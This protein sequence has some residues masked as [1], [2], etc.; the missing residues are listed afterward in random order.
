MKAFYPTKSCTSALSLVVATAMLSSIAVGQEA[1]WDGWYAG[2]NAGVTDT[3]AD[4]R[5]IF[6]TMQGLGLTL[7]SIDEDDEDN[8]FKALLGY[9][10]N[11]H[12]AVEASGFDLG[13]FGFRSVIAPD[14]N[15]AGNI[16]PMGYAL[17]AVG[18]L[19]FSE[20]NMLFARV[21]LNY[22]EVREYFSARNL[23]S[24]PFPNSDEK[25]ANYKFGVGFQHDFSGRLSM[26]AEWEHYNLDEPIGVMDDANFYSVGLLYRFGGNEV[27]P[28]VAVADAAPPSPPPP[29]PPPPPP[30]PVRITLSAEALFDF[31]R[32]TLKPAGKAELDDLITALGD[33]D[34][35]LINVTG[36]TDRIGTEEYNL[37]L[38]QRRADT[39]KDYL[40]ASRSWVL[41]NA[42]TCPAQRRLPV[43]NLTVVSK[44]K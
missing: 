2:F 5:P 1:R 44:S 13:K 35:D 10:F 23:A 8:G 17:D 12:F 37:D 38:S 24:H 6:T 39:V 18:M 32:D 27:A 29:P 34:Y 19:P 40:A 14:S 11:R 31:D 25:D 3:D 9:R 42:G 20:T 43:C 26:R 41:I 33:V 36:H 16:R 4:G 28:P 7:T 30:A 22:A 15:L 21:G